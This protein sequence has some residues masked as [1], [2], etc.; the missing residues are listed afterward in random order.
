[1]W[2]IVLSLLKEFKVALLDWPRWWYGAGLKQEF[3]NYLRR[4]E[5]LNRRL[6]VMVWLKNIFRPMFGQKD[7]EGRL[8]SFGIRLVQIVVRGALWVLGMCI[9]LVWLNV[10]IF[11]PIVFVCLFII[12]YVVNLE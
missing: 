1:M 12:G 7:W 6:A 10:Y 11:A 2:S 8:I 3:R 9:N 5:Y 4:L